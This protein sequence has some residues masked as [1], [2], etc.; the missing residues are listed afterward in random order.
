MAMKRIPILVLV[1]LGAAAT[2]PGV[3]I[4]DDEGDESQCNATPCADGVD[5]SGKCKTY[6][7]FSCNE[8]CNER[9]CDGG[10]TVAGPFYCSG[11][12]PWQLCQCNSCGSGSGG[13]G[14]PGDGGGSGPGDGGGGSGCS[15]CLCSDE[16]C[17]NNCWWDGWEWGECYL[18]E[19][20]CHSDLD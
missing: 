18:G 20:W 2:F 19:C 4:A 17:N 15:D 11:V 12:G 3:A 5:S 8:L 7:G 10:S 6:A 1:L 9:Q 13:S 14:D 16:V